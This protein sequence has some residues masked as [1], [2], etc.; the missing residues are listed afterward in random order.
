MDV[1]DGIDALSRDQGPLFAVVGVFD[2]LH[3]GHAYLLEHLVAEATARSARPS[4][5]TFDHH[6]D[7]IL[8]GSAPPLLLDPQERLERLQAAGVEVTVV[9]HFD[10]ALRRTTY[11]AFVERIRSRTALAGFLLTPD[12]AFGYERRGTP[13]ALAALGS[14]DGFE[15]VVIPPFTLDGQS[16]RSSA[17]RDAVA[18]GD[19]RQAHRLLGRP[20]AIT[21]ALEPDGRLQFPLPM[22][23]P[24][25][26][27]YPC[28][29]RGN[30]V[31]MTIESGQAR[32]DT[33]IDRDGRTEIPFR[34]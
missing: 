23:L 16:I 28:D 9:Q 26:G 6:P 24:P 7:E 31:T 27:R 5:I 20:F 12:A 3:R 29:V 21:A 14:R 32:L 30:P 34:A 18:A 17:I 8:T 1:V 4:V 10:E 22:S 33:P 19:L 25:N 2:G 13:D 11:D 15:V